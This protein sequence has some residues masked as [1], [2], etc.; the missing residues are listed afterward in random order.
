MNVVLENL[1]RGIWG[2]GYTN[3]VEIFSLFFFKESENLYQ[4]R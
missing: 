3:E 4:M 2:M 1:R